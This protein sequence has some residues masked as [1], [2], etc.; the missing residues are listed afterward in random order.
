MGPGKG[1][2]AP[3]R[4]IESTFVLKRLSTFQVWTNVGLSPF[5]EWSVLMPELMANE[6]MSA[7]GYTPKVMFQKAGDFYTSLGFPHLPKEF[8]EFSVMQRPNGPGSPSCH[9]SAFDFFNGK[10]FRIRQC[11]EVS[12][13][14]RRKGKVSSQFCCCIT[15][16]KGWP[17]PPVHRDSR[18]GPR[19]VLPS[20]QGPQLPV[21][22]RR[23]P[24][25]PRGRRRRAIAGRCIDQDH[26]T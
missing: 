12:L 5:P 1:L 9:A 6:G 2:A 19:A 11:A 15:P 17:G 21:P 23:Q 20:L 25:F 10:D 18:D 24:G 4:S 22:R 26:L 16:N 13:K 8:W 14:Y 7:R 3:Q